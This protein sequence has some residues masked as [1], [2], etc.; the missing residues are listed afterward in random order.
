MALL[1]MAI[2]YLIIGCAA[3]VDV[4]VKRLHPDTFPPRAPHTVLDEWEIPPQRSYIEIAKLIA[5]SAGKDEADRVREGLLD[6]ARQLGA[7]G[8]ILHKPDVLE[9]HGAIRQNVAS[10]FNESQGGQSEFTSGPGFMEEP[11]SVNI[12]WIYLISF[13]F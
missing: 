8:I 7:D 3:R 11:S 13:R 10:T 1:I 5:T 4:K 2:G 6:R 12:R 9:E